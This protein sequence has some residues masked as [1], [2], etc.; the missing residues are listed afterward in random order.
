MKGD[1]N[2]FRY[3]VVCGFT[4]QGGAGSGE[5]RQSEAMKTEKTI[6][7]TL[8]YQELKKLQPGEVCS[9]ETLRAV[10][11]KDPQRTGYTF[12]F[13]AR[14]MV[15]R[16]VECVLEAVPNV[17][18]KRLPPREVI[19]RGG[20]DL[21]GVRR[22]IHSGLR[23]QSTVVPIEQQGDLTLE[24]RQKFNVQLSQFGILQAVAGRKAVNRIGAAVARSSQPIESKDA[25]RL[26]VESRNARVSTTPSNP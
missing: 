2:G 25:L 24:E 12:I 18:I 5:T 10:I 16:E 11:D 7:T 9:Y 1:L 22:R 21:K 26:L 13:S 4:G 23:R 6:E 15:E 3:R 8:A 19:N 14:R 17:G 20:R